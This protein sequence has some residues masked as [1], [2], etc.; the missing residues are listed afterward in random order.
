MATLPTSRRGT[1]RR[2]SAGPENSRDTL[3]ER[4][5]R[6]EENENTDPPETGGS[7]WTTTE[8]RSTREYLRNVT[9]AT[10]LTLL[11]SYVW[12]GRKFNTVATESDPILR[13]TEIHPF[14]EGTPI[15]IDLNFRVGS[16][17]IED[18]DS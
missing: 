18:F 4:K 12:H 11:H 8:S 15:P 17:T 6:S 3:P 7:D 1:A 5:D 9:F 10:A 13:L 2:H 16:G 14:V